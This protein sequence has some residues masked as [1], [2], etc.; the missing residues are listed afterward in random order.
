V[1][2]VLS[3]VCAIMLGLIGFKEGRGKV[4]KILGIWFLFS[5]VIAEVLL[6]LGYQKHFRIFSFYYFSVFGRMQ[7]YAWGVGLVAYYVLG[8]RFRITRLI[9]KSILLLVA[10]F[11]A[12]AVFL[13]VFRFGVNVVYWDQWRAVPVLA[14]YINGTLK[15]S[16]LF[17]NIVEQREFFGTI[18]TII[19]AHITRYNTCVEMYLNA[20]ILLLSFCVILLA[21]R[22]RIPLM[23]NLF[24][25]APVSY[26]ILSPNQMSNI[27]Y[28]AGLS[29]VL[30][31]A[32]ALASLYLLH[33]AAKQQNTKK[34][35][36][37][38]VAAA[39]LGTIATFSLSM[40]MCVWCAGLIQ[41]LLSGSSSLR[42]QRLIMGSW[43]VLGLLESLFY[44]QNF[45]FFT[46]IVARPLA[47]IFSISAGS[48]FDYARFFPLFLG[49]SLTGRFD[50]L[51][52]GI[53]VLSLL[54]VC[55]ALMYTYN[56]WKENALWISI[57]VFAVC[58]VFLIFVGRVCVRA[59]PNAGFAQRYIIFSI[60]IVVSLYALMLDLFF[61][62][63]DNF[64]VSAV[65]AALAGLIIIS[66]PLSVL[67]GLS[68]AEGQKSLYTK[69]ASVL[70]TYEH[71]SDDA[72]KVLYLD[73][74]FVRKNAA[75]LK[76]LKYNVFSTKTQGL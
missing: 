16:H 76:R 26:L 3:A 72:L 75:V 2:V 71:Q 27:L 57:L 31:H 41:V 7:W 52:W 70:V 29:W 5:V 56:Q 38:L 61:K 51:V 22:E 8:T 6:L 67:K 24:F 65:Y 68:Y 32:S 25:I 34:A 55:M 54:V 66:T 19:T 15:F 37:S 11:P 33:V 30:V 44:F 9:A 40:G 49:S 35:I 69:A 60:L 53:V 62:F 43:V 47:S 18:I 4:L 12:S 14:R 59:N 50:S 28:G 73:P 63:K 17:E 48:H 20:C 64:V 1:S 45:A 23:R 39:L 58:A 42:R 21:F 46:Q 10:F 13:F 74:G 36:F